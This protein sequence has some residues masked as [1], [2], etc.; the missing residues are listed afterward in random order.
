MPEVALCER[1]YSRKKALWADGDRDYFYRVQ[2]I[3]LRRDT[4]GWARAIVLWP[5]TPDAG[6]AYALGIRHTCVSGIDGK[7]SHFFASEDYVST[8]PFHGKAS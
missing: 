1:V 3:G 8:Q 7:C 5:D 6:C 2:A 4:P